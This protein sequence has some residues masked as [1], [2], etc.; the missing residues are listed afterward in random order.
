MTKPLCKA[1]HASFNLRVVGVEEDKDTTDTS[2]GIIWRV[3][4]VVCLNTAT[5]YSPLCSWRKHLTSALAILWLIMDCSSCESRKTITH[6]LDTPSSGHLTQIWFSVV[7]MFALS[8]EFSVTKEW[9]LLLLYSMHTPIQRYSIGALI[10]VKRIQNFNYKQLS[11]AY[12][13]SLHLD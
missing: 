5:V 3:S 9:L 8:P 1:S 4:F 10:M 11:Q 2:S 7:L 13:D 6:P 12:V